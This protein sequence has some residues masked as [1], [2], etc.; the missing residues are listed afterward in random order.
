MAEDKKDKDIEVT[1][2]A[3][4]VA[5]G[6]GAGTP[7]SH[8]VTSRRDFLKKSGKKAGTVA[9]M[10]AAALLSGSSEAEAKMYWAEWFQKNYRLMN[11]EEKAAS[12]ARLEE[13]YSE[14]FGKERLFE[15]LVSHGT[16]SGDDLLRH[17]RHAVLLFCGKS[18]LDDDISMLV[19]KVL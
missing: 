18:E 7:K 16:E 4:A 13:R 11:D 5:T 8:E 19:V 12:I 10:G 2:E 15:V 3:V 14:E 1:E 9:F 6:D 17:I